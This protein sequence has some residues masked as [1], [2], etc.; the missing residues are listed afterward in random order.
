GFQ[1]A[2]VVASCKRSFINRSKSLVNRLV[3]VLRFARAAPSLTAV[4]SLVVMALARDNPFAHAG[5]W[6]AIFGKCVGVM[7]V[8]TRTTGGEFALIDTRDLGELISCEEILI[9]R[10]YNLSMVPFRPDLIID[11]GAHIGL[12]TLLAG[13]RY[14]SAEL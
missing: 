7:K 14:S 11:C 13:L 2:Q 10:T 4:P 6:N 8:R 1:A 3:R 12:F 9:D 5:R